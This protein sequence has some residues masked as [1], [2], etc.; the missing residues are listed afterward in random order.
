MKKY[1]GIVIILCLFAFSTGLALWSINYEAN[2]IFPIPYEELEGLNYDYIDE[3]GRSV[4]WST[5]D[6]QKYKIAVEYLNQ[7][8]DKEY[9]EL[10]IFDVLDIDFTLELRLFYSYDKNPN[11]DCRVGEYH[12][13]DDG[14][15]FVRYGTNQLVRLY[16]D[17]DFRSF[18]DFLKANGLENEVTA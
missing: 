6:W 5:T 11:R 14:T 17:V 7:L 13:V 8:T 10:E 2:R 3:D 4:S 15:V 12:F 18:V 16:E 9:R 1:S